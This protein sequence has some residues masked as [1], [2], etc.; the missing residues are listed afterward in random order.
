MKDLEDVECNYYC[1]E[2]IKIN[3]I[4]DR[5]VTFFLSMIVVWCYVNYSTRDILSFCYAG[6]LVYFL[7]FVFVLIK[8]RVFSGL[9]LYIVYMFSFVQIGILMQGLYFRFDKSIIHIILIYNFL[10]PLILLCVQYIK[11]VERIKLNDMHISQFWVTILFYFGS[12][13]NVLYFSLVGVI[14]LFAD[15]AENFRVEAMAGR[16]FLIIIAATTIKIA[17]VLTLNNKKR[18]S[19]MVIGCMLLLGTGFRSQALEIILIL[20][21]TYWIG[22]SKRYL[23]K[24]SVIIM[25]LSALYALVGVTRAGISWSWNKLYLPVIWRFYVNTYNF[26]TIYKLFPKDMIQYGRAFFN[27]IKVILPGAQ[28]TFMLQLKNI[29]HISFSGGSLTPSVFGEGYYNFGVVGA[30]VWPLVVLLFVHYIDEFNRKHIDSRIYY[31]LSFALVGLSTTSF[32]PV[33][34]N[35]YFPQLLV[36][37]FIRYLSKKYTIT[38]GNFHEHTVK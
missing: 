14:P 19:R 37:L 32:I 2:N 35:A 34:L 15:D 29:M 24:G 9:G 12:A 25:F 28:T 7:C 31:V 5:I 22:K 10:A 17:I 30:I 16:G 1:K 8:V 3:F 27:D 21:L 36:F 23:L 11:R 33:I 4:S 6:S 38:W 13:I 18:L 26:N 20:F